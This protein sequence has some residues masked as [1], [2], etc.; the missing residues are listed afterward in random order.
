MFRTMR[1]IHAQA[2]GALE[3]Q[4]SG[5]STQL[6]GVVDTS[7]ALAT[8]S[9]DDILSPLENSLKAGKVLISNG[10][11]VRCRCPKLNTSARVRS[12]RCQCGCQKSVFC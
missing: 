11:L 9:S 4:I 1:F 6:G 7:T 12:P 3:E 10:N 2:T 5:S 8:I